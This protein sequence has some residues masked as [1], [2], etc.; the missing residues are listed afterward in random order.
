MPASLS[1][2]LARR[3]LSGGLVGALGLALAPGCI[4]FVGDPSLETTACQFQG[5]TTACGS[6][7]KTS[8]QPQVNACCLDHDCAS[9]LTNLDLCAE[10]GACA[11]L[12]ASSGLAAL[13]SCVAA[14]CPSSCSS[15]TGAGNPDIACQTDSTVCTCALVGGYGYD[16]IVGGTN[17]P[18]CS[19]ATTGF[20]CCA[21]TG[22]P[23]ETSSC[24]CIGSLPSC[25]TTTRVSDCNP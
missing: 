16:S 13:G 18:T 15:V 2:I 20:V 11:S 17:V 5:E 3:A 7:I 24:N 19:E 12:A 8:C 22:W 14:A 25:A 10:T 21:Q 4:L 9:Q 23:S 6:C 1:R